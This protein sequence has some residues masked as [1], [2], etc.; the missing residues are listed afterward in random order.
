MK[1]LKNVYVLYVVFLISLLNI[2][3]FIY[4]NNYNNLIAFITCCLTVYLINHNMIIVL[5]I[6]MIIVNT[7]S[8]FNLVKIN[9][10]EL[11]EGARNNNNN[12]AYRLQQ[13]AYYRLLQRLQEVELQLKIDAE[14]K[15][16]QELA[17]KLAA[18]LEAKQKRIEYITIN[19][20]RSEQQKNPS[21]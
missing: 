11:K 8:M 13:E 18:K 7:L 5:G 20:I 4:Y 14:N 9:N 3:W 2:G 12:N 6:S 16:L 17:A 15:R 19:K 21:F 1:I 10:V